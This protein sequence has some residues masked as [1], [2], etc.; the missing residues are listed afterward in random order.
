MIESQLRELN[1]S[2]IERNMAIGPVFATIADLV[3]KFGRPFARWHLPKGRWRRGLG[4]LLRQLSPGGE[5]TT[6]RLR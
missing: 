5:D 2:L 1:L 4:T 3:L 6:V